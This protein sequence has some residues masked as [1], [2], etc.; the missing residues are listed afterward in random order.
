M[1]IPLANPLTVSKGSANQDVVKLAR[2]EDELLQAFGLTYESYIRAGLA[3]DNPSGLRLTPYHLLPSSE[4]IVAQLEQTVVST[5]SLFG[6]GKLGLPM[7][8][9]YQREIEVLRNRGYRLAEVGSL[10]DRR[11]SP[12]RFLTVFAEMGRLLAQVANA[13]NVDTLVAVVH[14]KHAKLYKRV[15]GFKQIGDHTDCPYANGNPAEALYLHFDDYLGTE[16]HN[17]FFG[18]PIPA[19][20]LQPYRWNAETRN[21]FRR[22]LESDGKIVEVVGIKG[23]YTW[24]VDYS[25][26]PLNLA[27]HIDIQV[28][29]H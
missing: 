23:Y 12:R 1:F 27:S 6:D 26:E 16:L 7:Q 10:A 28:E 14:P 20:Q 11:A 15:L 24:G 5:I 13:R 29:Q 3:I 8:S 18:E 21:Y 19:S 22:I 25:C 4:V 2:S 17:Q 9:M